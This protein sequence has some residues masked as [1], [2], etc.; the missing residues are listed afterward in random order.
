L[1]LGLLTAAMFPRVDPQRKS[2]SDTLVGEEPVF[3]SK[4]IIIDEKGYK[5]LV[6]CAYSAAR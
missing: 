4:G 6:K 5:K 1:V 3:D 2:S